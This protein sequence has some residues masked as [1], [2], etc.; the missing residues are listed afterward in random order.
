[1]LSLLLEAVL[2][3]VVVFFRSVVFVIPALA[4]GNCAA[5]T[6]N[7]PPAGS[8]HGT[9]S[10]SSEQATTFRA[11]TRMVTLEVVA[12]DHQGRAATGLTASDFQVFEQSAGRNK[13]TRE[14]KIAAFQA[15]GIAQIVSQQQSSLHVPAGVYTNLIMLHTQPVPPTILLVDGINTKLSDQ[16]Q[17]HAQMIRMLGSLP[18]DVPVA[19]F[20]LGRRLR[21]LQGF[22]TD[23]LLLKVAL[24]I[25][26]STQAGS[27]VEMDPRDDP[28]SMSAFRENI[29]T[30]D[31]NMASDPMQ[32]IFLQ[33]IRRFERETYASNM[34]IRVRETVEALMS[35]ARNVSGYPGRKNLLW[36][37]SSFPIVLN[38]EMDI[39]GI[40]Q[41][42]QGRSAAPAFT[43]PDTN[44]FTG[45]RNYG[46]EMQEVANALSEAK[47][48]VYPIDVGGVETE[49]FFD[50]DSRPRARTAETGATAIKEMG[51][52]DREG[53]MKAGQR[54]TMETIAA[55][56]GGRICTGDNDLGD[57]IRLAVNDSSAFYEIS[58][59]PTSPDWNGEFRKVI[60]KTKRPGLHLAYRQG[61]FARAQNSADPKAAQADLQQAACQDYLNATSI[62]LM[63]QALPTDSPEK[64]KYYIA[65]DLSM[66]TFT[67]AGDDARALNINV[68]VCTFDKSGKPL[69][70]SNEPINYKLT[71]KEYES[72]LR[73]HGLAHVISVPGPKP[74]GVRL[75]VQDVPSGRLG[76]V[77][78]PVPQPPAGVPPS[79][80]SAQAPESH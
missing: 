61:Y 62:L 8:G 25:A 57:C 39:V 68:A 40:T 63:A 9:S 46:A 20:L 53:Q 10:V 54:E 51:A 34:D 29:V 59:Y 23:P 43:N 42:P 60:V 33:A 14:Q 50:A 74:A 27:M 79:G 32:A 21:M 67:P 37:S 35:L 1:M 71:S 73:M 26:S 78:V 77:N 70:L 3:R 48:A 66:L 64:L 75:V 65:I 6:L 31:P 22:T 5:Q 76:S 30:N 80:N 19:V 56:T 55:Q 15:I 11:T 12:R 17:V 2:R 4:A 28:D 49:A 18:K 41:N 44:S 47:L 13:Q 52:L 16:M 45:M 7:T 38:P 69:Q 24:E 72:L 36:I 58:Y